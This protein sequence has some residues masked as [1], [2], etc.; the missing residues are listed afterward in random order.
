MSRVLSSI[1]DALSKYF[2]GNSFIDPL[3]HIDAYL[4]ATIKR[5]LDSIPMDFRIKFMANF[6]PEFIKFGLC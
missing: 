4:S 1:M 5:L 6:A 3:G 2:F